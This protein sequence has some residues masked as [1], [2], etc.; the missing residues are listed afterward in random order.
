MAG[1][2]STDRVRRYTSVASVIDTLRRRQLTLLDPQSWDDRND[3][4][5]MA[6][7]KD[8]RGARALYALC[9]AR[10]WETYH[11]WRVF[12]GGSDGAC[13]ELKREPL[14]AALAKD[15][16]LRFGPVAYM[17]IDDVQK[18]SKAHRDALPFLKRKPYEPEGEYR[19][20]AET[21]EPQSTALALP[22]ELRWIGR[23]YLS[24]WLPD[25]F[26]ESVKATLRDIPG[27]RSLSVNRTTLLENSRWKSAGDRLAGV[28]SAP[29][30][31]ALVER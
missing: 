26:F 30:H 3:R 2:T 8:H 31:R 20:V 22:I 15:A 29:E 21:D 6:L 1:L 14:E 24:P 16:R 19:I 4:H 25:A 13:I 28:T 5:F 18:L 23:I 11:H 10:S 7:Y 17:P 27:C 9:A 12:A